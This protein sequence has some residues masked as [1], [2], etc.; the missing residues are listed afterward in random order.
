[1][2][3][4]KH[5]HHPAYAA[6]ATRLVKNSRYQTLHY[7]SLVKLVSK[8]FVGK[9]T[10]PAN[11]K[12]RLLSA[13]RRLEA[14]GQLRSTGHSGLNFQLY[15][16]ETVTRRITGLSSSPE[17][18]RQDEPEA[19][20]IPTVS[21]YDLNEKLQMASAVLSHSH[22]PNDVDKFN[23]ASLLVRRILQEQDR[24]SKTDQQTFY[25]GPDE[26][27]ISV[28]LNEQRI[29]MGLNERGIPM[30]SNEQGASVGL[31]EQRVNSVQ[32][33]MEMSMRKVSAATILENP[34]IVV[35][36]YNDRINTILEED[37]MSTIS[38][39][40]RRENIARL[41]AILEAKS[42]AIA[43]LEY[44]RQKLE[45]ELQTQQCSRRLLDRELET[46]DVLGNDYGMKLD[47][48]YTEEAQHLGQIEA[49]VG[50]ELTESNMAEMAIQ[51]DIKALKA[52]AEKYDRLFGAMATRIS[53]CKQIVNE[54]MP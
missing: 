5:S 33:S 9:Y 2:T 46:L 52:V 34:E 51:E 22:L 8:Q 16:E 43:Q 38:S 4:S 27:G 44:S 19:W 28:G 11:W 32:N 25:V 17:T 3:D 18:V 48:I 30:E 54:I 12:K 29:P 10:F 35:P 14:H 26:R 50:E 40:E 53:E 31:D 21:D 6:I 41:R 47:E 15:K 36:M 42:D 7:L 24:R 23:L 49:T 20:S 45:Q 39:S 1:M 13:L 37:I